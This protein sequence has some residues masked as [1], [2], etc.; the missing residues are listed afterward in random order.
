[1]KTT[2][3]IVFL[4]TLFLPFFSFAD[5]DIKKVGKKVI[6][7]LEIDSSFIDY[8]KP[9]KFRSEDGQFD[10]RLR[11]EKFPVL[12]PNCKSS[13]IVRMPSTLN[14]DKDDIK[15]KEKIHGDIVALKSNEKSK[16]QL[17]IEIQS[18][19]EI[20]SVEPFEGKLKYCNV[21]FVPPDKKIK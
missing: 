3:R 20:K 6:L 9:M 14:Q 5:L 21:Y 8:K 18:Y 19:A 12:A 17:K 15:A 10:L 2:N 7:T 4:V 13:I 16:L 1:M 11:R